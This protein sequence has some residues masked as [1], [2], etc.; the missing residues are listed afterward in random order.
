VTALTWL[1][2]GVLGAAGACTRFIVD[3]AITARLGGDL[4]FGTLVVNLTGAFLLGLL[5]G[6][7]VRGDAYVLEGTATIGSYTT[8][9]TWMLETHRLAEDGE[10]RRA[11]ANIVLSVGLGIGAAALGRVLGGAL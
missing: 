1:G 2:V 7:A 10:A 6:A 9:S 8:F 11:G 3:G 4:P 5:V